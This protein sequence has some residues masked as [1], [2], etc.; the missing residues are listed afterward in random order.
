MAVMSHAYSSKVLTY[1]TG[2]FS[3]LFCLGQSQVLN[4]VQTFVK[5]SVFDVLG[6]SFPGFRVGAVP[7]VWD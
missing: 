6:Q 3:K 4:R 5:L 7:A 1:P 2:E